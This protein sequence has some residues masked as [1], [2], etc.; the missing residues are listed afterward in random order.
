METIMNYINLTKQD[1]EVEEKLLASYQS[2]LTQLPPG[3]LTYKHNKGKIYYYCTDD[4]TGRQ[5]YISRQN[6]QLI[7]DLKQKRLLQKAVQI[8]DENLKHQKKL[9]LH[10]QDYDTNR[11]Q[12]MLPKVYSDAVLTEYEA[13]DWSSAGYRKNPYHPENLTHRTSFGMTVRSKSEVLIAEL[14]HKAE[15]PFRYECEL[16]IRGRDGRYHRYYPDFTILTPQGQLI[17]WE[18]LGRLDNENY[19]KANFTR[20]LDFYDNH[21]VAPDNLILTMD[22]PDGTIDIAA[23]DRIIKGQLLPLFQRD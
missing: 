5:T 14:L 7:Y 17:Y 11:I 10:Y 12:E 22:G 16:S 15:I 23:I 2:L 21:I 8:L 1:I 20:L 18:H 4:R 9:L 6:K 19:A 3:R 13:A